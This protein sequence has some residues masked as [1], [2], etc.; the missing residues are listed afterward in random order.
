LDKNPGL[1]QKQQNPVEKNKP[2]ERE[3]SSE[4]SENQKEL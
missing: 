4:D 3:R 2:K 1:P